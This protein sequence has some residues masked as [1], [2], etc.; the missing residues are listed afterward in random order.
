MDGTVR[1]LAVSRSRGGAGRRFVASALLALTLALALIAVGTGLLFGA[2]PSPASGLVGS[3]GPGAETEA[4]LQPGWTN[5]VEECD[6]LF[7][8]Q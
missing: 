5:A 4:G 3:S 1:T 7:G 8:G 2:D 6:C